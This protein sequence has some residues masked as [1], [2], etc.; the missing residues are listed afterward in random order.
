M[1]T[2]KENR[3]SPREAARILRQNLVS[4]I[5]TWR[6]KPL[7]SQQLSRS[8]SDHL[9]DL[10]LFLCDH[11][12][13]ST[14]ASL[15][16]ARLKFVL[17]DACTGHHSDF[18]TRRLS[19]CLKDLALLQ[20]AIADFFKPYPPLSNLTRS[21]LNR[22]FNIANESV[23]SSFAHIRTR[24]GKRKLDELMRKFN[25]ADHQ[26]DQ[27]FGRAP[28]PMAVLIGREYLYVFANEAYSSL[29]KRRCLERRVSDVFTNE[30]TA[31]FM[32]F[33]EKVWATQEPVQGNE[34]CFSTT[35]LNGKLVQ[36]C[37]CPGYYPLK[38]RSGEMIGITVIHMDVTERVRNENLRLE[39]EATLKQIANSLPVLIWT[40]DATGKTQWCNDRWYEFANQPRSS[41]GD[42]PAIEIHPDDLERVNKTWDACLKTGQSY[43]IEFR[44]RRSKDDQYRWML[45]RAVPIFEHDGTIK[46]WVAS[47]TDITD[48][49]LA[50]EALAAA[51]H[52]AKQSAE[53]RRDFL[54]HMS[55]EIRTPLTAI[56]GFARLLRE[57]GLTETEKENFLDRIIRS[58]SGLS[59]L[60]NNILDLSKVDSGHLDLEA[61]PMDLQQL[62]L[63]VVDI[64][65]PVAATKSIRLVTSFP[66]AGDFVVSGDPNRVRQIL[67]NL[68]GNAIKFT[69]TGT[70][71]ISVLKLANDLSELIYSIKVHDTGVGLSAEQAARLFKPF[72][73]A[74]TSTA[75]RF[76]GTGIGLSLSKR[77]AQEMGGDLTLL[78]TDPKAGTTFECVLKFKRPDPASSL[79]N[80]VEKA[81]THTPALPELAGLRVLI[82]D[83]SDD[84]LELVKR[85]LRKKGLLVEIAH[86]G[87]EAI[88][89]SQEQPFD[90]ILMDIEMPQM[91]GY[92]TLG[93]LRKRGYQ[94][95]VIALTAQA[96]LEERTKAIAAGFNDHVTKPIDSERLFD[97]IVRS[98]PSH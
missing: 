84:N 50:S 80:G 71:T 92:E 42:I 60:I 21:R 23:L 58:G 3:L 22:A 90:L 78:S 6:A 63:D 56:I 81:G 70:I 31:N 39:S 83:D 40:A 88:S 26:L 49:K 19:S 96:L 34:F 4:I 54:A 15:A 66:S 28:L 14:S 62:V 98:K 48:I 82:T 79:I 74:D 91:N 75:R 36:R 8:V 35:D 94:K 65:Q 76:G 18:P 9:P 57:K 10:I 68:L 77:L 2:Q 20:H 97:A 29:T 51:E 27:F 93:E 37:L 24:S 17:R 12:S 52:S 47:S 73:Q 46:L 43:E 11:L 53:A 7:S 44:R 41:S 67:I 30:E 86:N 87:E 85:L 89:K 32:P 61:T 72:S 13:N 59:L 95:P 33:L 45:G 69:D 1:P 38:D 64:Y 5:A 55:H 16:R 25:E